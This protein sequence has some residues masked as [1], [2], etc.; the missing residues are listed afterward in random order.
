MPPATTS[1]KK[2]DELFGDEG[3]FKVVDQVAWRE[4]KRGICDLAQFAPK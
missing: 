1:E 3:F 4:K 2:E